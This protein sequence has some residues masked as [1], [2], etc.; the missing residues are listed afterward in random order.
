[1]S[2]TM[3]GIL[4]RRGDGRHGAARNGLTLVELLVVTFILAAMAASVVGVTENV[5][6]AQ[7][8][9]AT[10]D[11][12]QAMRVAVLGPEQ[13][14]GMPVAAGYIQDLGWLPSDGSH[15]AVTGQAPLTGNPMEPGQRIP[16]RQWISAW[17]CWAGWGGP[18]LPPLPARQGGGL[19]WYDGWGNDWHGWPTGQ[20]AWAWQVPGD[21]DFQAMNVTSW[22]PDGV[23][24]A[25]DLPSNVLIARQEWT[26]D[27]N[28]WRVEVRNFTG[29]AIPIG[30]VR[31]KLTLPRWDKATAGDPAPALDHPVPSGGETLADHIA[32]PGVSL[33]SNAAAIPAAVGPELP[34][35][36]EFTYA[37]SERRVAIGARTLW[38]VNEADG[39]RFATT[40]YV[41]LMLHPRL[42]PGYQTVP[43]VGLVRLDVR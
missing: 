7:R 39:A 14:G 42:A 8:Q 21:V 23:A 29:T 30:S 40:A 15:L 43:P 20:P 3:D 11:R 36:Y 10:L 31:L 27:L 25:D 37:T 35:I 2:A 24:G 33:A 22:G 18:Y 41:H 12:L 6:R 17:R 13:S 26:V 5:D 19:P 34:G 16:A 4:A 9:Q 1:M 32:W 28:G 38:L